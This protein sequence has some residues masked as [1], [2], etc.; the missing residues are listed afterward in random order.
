MEALKAAGVL[1]SRPPVPRDE[2]DKDEEEDEEE[3][4]EAEPTD[5]NEDEDASQDR[6]PAALAVSVRPALVAVS[7]PPLDM[8][9]SEDKLLACV[10]VKV[11][12]GDAEGTCTLISPWKPSRTD[13]GTPPCSLCCVDTDG[14]ACID[15]DDPTFAALPVNILLPVL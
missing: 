13:R 3:E 4:D 8:R 11:V 5:S 14:A 9:P 10:F 1:A 12:V 2:T 15:A 7:R 6:E